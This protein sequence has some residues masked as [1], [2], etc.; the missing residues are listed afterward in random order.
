[1]TSHISGNTPS[2]TSTSIPVCSV[3]RAAVAGRFWNTPQSSCVTLTVVPGS[4]LRI[5]FLPCVVD[6]RRAVDRGCAYAV[7]VERQKL[8]RVTLS[9]RW[10][11]RHGVRKRFTVRALKPAPHHKN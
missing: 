8:G 11:E 7:D 9:I 4:N 6:Y 3:K 1:M 10:A 2:V 5:C